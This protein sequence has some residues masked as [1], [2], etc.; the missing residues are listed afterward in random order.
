[1]MEINCFQDQPSDKFGGADFEQSRADSYGWSIEKLDSYFS[2][3]IDSRQKSHE[4][5]FTSG[6]Y[7]TTNDI[8]R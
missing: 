8:F 6:R 5:I 2:N 7:E 4:K 1:M 3:Y